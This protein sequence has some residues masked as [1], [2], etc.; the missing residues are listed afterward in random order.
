M[1]TAWKNCRCPCWSFK[2]SKTFASYYWVRICG[3]MP[4]K[5]KSSSRFYTLPKPCKQCHLSPTFCEDFL[6]SLLCV[7]EPNYLVDVSR[8]YLQPVQGSECHNE[9]REMSPDQFLFSPHTPVKKQRNSS[10]GTI[11][12]PF[13]DTREITYLE[14]D[15]LPLFL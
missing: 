1:I 2:G 11:K 15:L 7:L 8:S 12:N 14:M 5:K 9:S 4:C 10:Q 3:E 13:I 6:C